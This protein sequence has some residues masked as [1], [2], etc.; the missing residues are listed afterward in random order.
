MTCDKC[1]GKLVIGKGENEKEIWCPSCEGLDV[2]AKSES[3]KLIRKDIKNL[4]EDCIQIIRKYDKDELIGSLLATREGDLLKTIKEG[5]FDPGN[6]IT[7]SLLI[8][9]VVNTHNQNNK[10]VE[11]RSQKF[12]ELI[13]KYE[14]L[15]INRKFFKLLDLNYLIFVGMPPDKIPE[16]TIDYEKNTEYNLAPEYSEF[17]EKD[18]MNIGKFTP[19]WNPIIENY[20]KFKLTSKLDIEESLRENKD[21]ENKDGEG[22]DYLKSI[23]RII[24]SFQ[25]FTPNMD[26]IRYP[27]LKDKKELIDVLYNLSQKNIDR[28][29]E[30][31]YEDHRNYECSLESENIFEIYKQIDSLGVDFEEF[32]ELFIFDGIEIEDEKIPLIY[33]PI[34]TQSLVIPPLSLNRM[35]KYFE[36]RYKMDKDEIN[37]KYGKPFENKIAKEMKEIGLKI[38]DPNNPS[39]NLQNIKDDEE[40]PSFEIDII[41][42][43]GSNIYIIDCKHIILTYNFMSGQR[44]NEI[45]KKLNG[46]DDK[47]EKRLTFVEKNLE[48]FGFESNKDWGFKSVIITLLR[49][50]VKSIGETYLISEDNLENIYEIPTAKY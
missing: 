10:K 50:P 4:N 24:L 44:I 21:R 6:F 36:A 32:E 5:V 18:R 41:G 13:N 16:Y 2:L 17:E 12:Q 29:K 46:I 47:Q 1:G 20:R 42:Y 31:F 23:I 11:V 27:S 25:M 48:E 35:Y 15:T 22:I 26:L 9:E 38:E 7:I 3:K 43:E 39:K 40:K 30:K 14:R 8:Q 37:S 49:E 28:L 33:R 34:K 45:K 19:K